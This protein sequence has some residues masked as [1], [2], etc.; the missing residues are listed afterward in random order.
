MPCCYSMNQ[1]I[2]SVKNDGLMCGKFKLQRKLTMSRNLLIFI[3]L[4]GVT[5]S[6]FALDKPSAILGNTGGGIQLGPV[7]AYPSMKIIAGHDDNLFRT[8]TNKKST[9]VGVVRPAVSLQL[10][11]NIK[12][13][14]LDYSLEAGFYENSS[15]DN[16]T[17]QNLL[18]VF[19]YHP[20]TKL[21]MAMRLEYLDEHDPRGTARTEGAIGTL[22][23][24]LDPDKW[25]SYGAGGLVSYGSPN[26]T[27]RVEL[28]A[29][30]VIKE[31]D[32]NRLF[33]FT[34]DRDDFNLR[35]TF[36]YR[37]RPKTQLL[38]EVKQT[39]FDYDRTAVGTPRLDSTDREYLFG[40]AWDATYK[41]TGFAKFGVID[42]DFDSDFRKDSNNFKWEVG[43]RW[44]PRTYSTVDISTE[45]RRDETNGIGDS[46]DVAEFKIAW[47]HEWRSYISSTINFLYGK[48]DYSSSIREDTRYGAGIKLNY[49][50][51]RW[52]KIS[53]GYEYE[54]R[55]SDVR[56][57]DYD[58][59]LFELTLD[60]TL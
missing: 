51:R 14:T 42:K 22:G 7:T 39:V 20:T 18:G 15:K 9:M 25:H 57:F 11:D 8:R 53:A 21:K 60:L 47:N 31:Y 26:A 40:A 5:G 19:E 52:A 2:Q 29:S 30:Y 55:N 36:F 59:N 12:T 49:D 27:G 24:T 1:V 4:C 28:E 17:D 13:L 6:S 44:R 38:F 45:R 16:Y 48:D 10:Q 37:I 56:I 32:N 41:T 43:A 33:T 35:G 34:R 3:V 23:G 46:I 54:E 50:W 58:R